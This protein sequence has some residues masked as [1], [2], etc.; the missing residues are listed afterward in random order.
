MELSYHNY[1]HHCRDIGITINSN[2]SPSLHIHEIT[3]KANQRANCILRCFVS[4]NIGLLVRA[5][6]V[7]VRPMLENNSIIWSPYLKQ[8]IMSDSLP[9]KASW[10]QRLV[11][12]AAFG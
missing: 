10:I 11:I 2:L 6:V 5:F 8:D 3:T 12:H 7:Y 4:G 1:L 9:K